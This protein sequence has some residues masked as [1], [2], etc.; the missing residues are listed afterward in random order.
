[1]VRLIDD[2]M[3]I[4]RIS[5]G[6]LDL[7]KEN[8]ELSV[9]LNNAMEAACP[10]MDEMNHS[11]HVDLPEQPIHIHADVTRLAQVF[12]NL[13][14]N[15]A[16]YSEPDSKIVLT[17]R[18]QDGEAIVKVSDSGIGIAADQ[19]PLIFELF[20]Q[21]DRSINKSQGGLGIGLTLV[22]R[23]VEM[24][25]GSVEAHSDG[26]G[27]GCEFVVRIPCAEHAQDIDELPTTSQASGHSMRIL[28][29]DDN[30]DGAKTLSMILK[31]SGN[32]VHTVFDG[33]SALAAVRENLFDVVLLDIGL[34]GMNGHEVCRGIRQMPH[35]DQ[36]VIIAQTGWSQDSDRR[37]T[38]EAGFDHHLTKPID[39]KVL[40]SLLTEIQNRKVL[41]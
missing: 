26:I 15:A 22:K 21:V 24:H 2:L 20:S 40:A 1:M 33:E 27:M 23:L 39:L 37:K 5:R 12:S 18:A 6:K 8:T 36:M 32:D 14:N 13:L 11:F 28:V 17:A 7:R 35:G 19:L 29:V 41:Q 10:V 16:K 4:S 38:K 3:D 31:L 9:I 34:P 30:H 25:G